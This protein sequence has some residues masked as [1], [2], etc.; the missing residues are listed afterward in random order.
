[1]P[2][3]VVWGD[4]HIPYRAHRLPP[5]FLKYV[6]RL[7]PSKL[8]CTG[9]LVTI[10]VLKIFRD[11][12][13]EVVAV[14]GNMDE[15]EA[16]KLPLKVSLEIN[17]LDIVVFHGHGIYPRGDSKKLYAIAKD[18][19]ADMILTGHTH[20]PLARKYKDV[21]I[22][23]PGS[24]CGVWG[25]SGGYGYPTWAVLDISDRRVRTKIMQIV[26]DRIEVY[27]EKSFEL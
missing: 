21:L 7:K 11:M 15:G 16:E 2:T 5:L 18:N 25:G 6:D 8:I 26:S 10:G 14:R 27:E 24:I 9:D 22:V 19:N 1:M 12:S 3:I 13:Y 4:S 17:D 20:S 23:N